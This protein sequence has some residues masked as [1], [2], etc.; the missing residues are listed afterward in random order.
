MDRG[1]EEQ[2][3][4]RGAK[5]NDDR[6][7]QTRIED[8]Q[9][10]IFIGLHPSEDEDRGGRKRIEDWKTEDG[11]QRINL[12]VLLRP[13]S[14]SV[15]GTDAGG[16][17]DTRVA[18]YPPMCRCMWYSAFGIS[19]AVAKAL[20]GRLHWRGSLRS[21]ARAPSMVATMHSASRANRWYSTPTVA[22]TRCNAWCLTMASLPCGMRR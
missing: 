5:D 12:L 10:S 21:T 2:T 7:R 6:R 9:S 1:M 20:V 8:R 14:S 18:Y 19:R 17:P 22:R 4:D 11:R 16:Y 13:S 3:E 15:L